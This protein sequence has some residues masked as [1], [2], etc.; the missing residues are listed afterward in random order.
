MV[1]LQF[2]RDRVLGNTQKAPT[3]QVTGGDPVHPVLFKLTNVLHL[4]SLT[5]RI[6]NIHFI[7]G[8]PQKPAAILLS[9]IVSK[10]RKKTDWTYLI[11]SNIDAEM[12]QNI[13]KD[14]T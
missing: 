8:R 6:H 13:V 7:Q 2:N 12:F 5:K 10:A 3:A 11:S 9:S 14:I 4:Q 1:G